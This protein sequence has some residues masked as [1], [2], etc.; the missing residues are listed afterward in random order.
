MSRRRWRL[1]A[2]G[3]AGDRK[4]VNELAAAL[5]DAWAALGLSLQAA[6]QGRA[7]RRLR[8]RPGRL[9]RGAAA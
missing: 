7:L 1:K 4:S 6:V 5:G 8:P 3:V 9:D 2:A